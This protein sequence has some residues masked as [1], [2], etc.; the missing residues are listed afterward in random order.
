[1]KQYRTR[2]TILILLTY[3]VLSGLLFISYYMLSNNYLNDKAE[4]NIFFI[5]D[6]VK[7]HVNINLQDDYLKFIDYYEEYKNEEDPVKEMMIN[8]DSITLQENYFLGFGYIKEEGFIIN[9][10][11]YGFKTLYSLSTYYNMNISIYPFS[12]ILEDYD[13]KN[14]YL[15]FQYENVIG[16]IDASLYFDSLFSSN[17]SNQYEYFIIHKDGYIFLADDSNYSTLRFGEY[18]SNESEREKFFT[19]INNETSTIFIMDLLGIKS[20]VSSQNLNFG[21][22]TEDIYLIQSFRY[23]NV[24]SSGFILARS[25]LYT[26]MVLSLIFIGLLFLGYKF[27]EIKFTDIEDAKLIH[28]Y[29]KP[30]IIYVNKKG[31]ILSCNKSFKKDIIDCKKI[32]SVYDL[33][34]LDNIDILNNIKKQKNVNIVVQTKEKERYIRFIPVKY[35]FKYALVGDDVTIIKNQYSSYKSI[36]F[37]N[38]ATNLPNSYFLK[39]DL[40]EILED[41]KSTKNN[42]LVMLSIYNFNNLNVLF[43]EKLL[44]DLLLEIKFMIQT[45]I[46]PYE[47]KLYNLY[48]DHFAILFSSDKKIEETIDFIFDIM[49]QM[50]RVI[51]FENNKLH[52]DFRV[53]VFSID[54]NHLPDLNPDKIYNNAALA[55]KKAENL[56]TK[57][58]VQ[59]DITL[60]Q[61]LTKRE[62]MVEDLR[63]AIE[64]EEFMVYLQP[65]FSTIQNRINGFEALVRWNNPKY[66]NDSPLEFIT[67]S[68]S[69]NMIVDIGKIIIKKTMELAKKLED[70]DIKISLNISPAQML[71]VGF[72]TELIDVIEEYQVNKK[73]LVIEVT[74]TFLMNNYNLVIEKLKQ[75]R[76]YGLS[77]HL[78]DF[79]T[80]YSS[81][82]YLK[83][84]PIDAI[85]IDKQFVDTLVNDK[86]SKAIISMIISLSK[87]LG[88]EVIAEGIESEKQFNVLKKMGC[89]VIQ[90]YYIGKA[91]E[92]DK[93]LALLNKTNSSEKEM[94]DLEDE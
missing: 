53:G 72:I 60:G 33:V 38:Q 43:S 45:L 23:D 16:Y 26:Y 51:D 70:Y 54:I 24:I 37:Y 35:L 18:I 15:V 21:N 63:V 1:M 46:E 89:N 34:T 88:L 40:L 80:G 62:L 42:V 44:T 76:K 59:Y 57:K 91:M 83:E 56:Q 75:L 87:N 85:K 22:N 47:A 12:D 93:A 64:K 19:K 71:Q 52:L 86:Y 41:K 84:L 48:Y 8:I 2:L 68:E 81:L 66:I 82:L 73:M 78:D 58:I 36:A 31:R 77:I 5:S 11:D 55:L 27:C 30:Y 74:E 17:N 90:G 32:K 25:L 7:T 6:T 67:I 65:Q 61:S 79:G 9:E 49:K 92:F 20:F 3:L 28:Y 69:N 13:I 94:E 14:N 29:N 4:E 39:S 10:T 50:D